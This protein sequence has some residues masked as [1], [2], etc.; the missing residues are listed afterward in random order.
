MKKL[1][2]V[3]AVFLLFSIT[4]SVIYFFQHVTLICSRCLLHTVHTCAG[5]VC[6][7]PGESVLTH[8]GGAALQLVAAGALELTVGSVVVFI[9]VTLH[10]AVVW[11]K[12]WAAAAHCAQQTHRS[13]DMAGKVQKKGDIRTY[14]NVI[15][16]LLNGENHTSTGQISFLNFL[17]RES[18]WVLFQRPYPLKRV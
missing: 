3:K 17:V 11:G 13:G 1:G 15:D 5:R 12:Q 2:H 6:A 7:G 18:S 9:T 16:R 10:V 8:P 4:S 14:I